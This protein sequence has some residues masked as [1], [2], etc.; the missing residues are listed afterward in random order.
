MIK[1]YGVFQL[2]KVIKEDKTK[3]NDSI[4]YFSAASRRTDKETDFKLFKIFGD[5]ADFF[6]RNLA[7][8]NDGKYQSRRMFIE[9]Y[10]ETYTSNRDVSCIAELTPDLIPQQI[11]LLKQGITVKAKTTIRVDQDT[12]V[13]RHMEFVD[14]P[15]DNGI[16][17]ILNSEMQELSSKHDDVIQPIEQSNVKQI[18]NEKNKIIN[19]EFKSLDDDEFVG[20]N[21]AD[22]V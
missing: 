3:K 7:K 9:G 10:V 6:I 22:N 18:S 19:E 16:E 8:D 5:Q 11:G 4:V 20:K 2:V 15:K 12:Y 17:I 21:I 1:F 14:K 13:V